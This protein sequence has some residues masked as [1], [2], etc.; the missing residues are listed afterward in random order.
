[1]NAQLPPR[2]PDAPDDLPDDAD[3]KALYD[4]LSQNEPGPALDA[5]VLRA[6]AEAVAGSKASIA[7]AQRRRARWPVAAGAAASVLLAAGLAWQMR[8]QP[9]A[10]LTAAPDASVDATQDATATPRA[11]APAP[12]QAAQANAMQESAALP[13]GEAAMHAEAVPPMAKKQTTE[14][15]RI[16]PKAISPTLPAPSPSVLP[17][18]PQKAM[19]MMRAM[20]SRIPAQSTRTLNEAVS[21]RVQA[22]AP[23]QDSPAITAAPAPRSSDTQADFAPLAPPP[24]AMAAAPPAPPAPPSP[25]SPLSP[26]AAGRA[27]EIEAAPSSG[28]A[29]TATPVERQQAAQALT[30]IRMLFAD[31]KR[32]Q[33]IKKLKAFQQA[34]PHWVLPADLHDE[35]A[36]P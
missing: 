11:D 26:P 4:R 20:T 32:P 8:T 21:G 5:A 29:L 9:S 16:A 17:A 1:M 12:M 35:L 36:R 27:L 19:P 18:Q 33:A 23:A 24:P 14:S 34:H 7:P 22:G 10:N 28:A 3:L 31:G 13:S 2:G 6:A 15:P 25:L 30:A